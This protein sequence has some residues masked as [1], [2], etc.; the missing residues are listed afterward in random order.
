M[1][2]LFFLVLLLLTTIV[3]N[4]CSK[5]TNAYS[6][7]DYFEAYFP[8][9][10]SLVE[11][12]SDNDGTVAAYNYYDEYDGITY[13]AAYFT[14]PPFISESNNRDVLYTLIRGQAIDYGTVLKYEFIKHEGNDEIL[15]VTELETASQL[16]YRFG[17]TAIK[18]NIVYQWVVAERDNMTKADKLFGEK[19]KYF[20]VLK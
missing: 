8:E 18:D 4:N 9:Q 12:Y 2:N 5:Q 15:F 10:P 14:L 19:L 11:R 16:V 1:K 13:M 6:I 17:V 20:R 3:I 7:D